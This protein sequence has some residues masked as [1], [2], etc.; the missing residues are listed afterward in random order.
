MTKI[1]LVSTVLLA[2]V[3]FVR[4]DDPAKSDANKTTS[5]TYLITGLHCP[6]CTSTVERSLS[7]APGIRSIKVDWNTKN[8]KIEFDESTVSAQKVSQLIAAT[9]HMMGPSM[10]YDSWLALKTP[11]VKDDATAKAAKDVLS[12]V[13]GVKK[14]EAFP[15]QHI[16]E[17][18]FASDGNATSAQLIDALTSAGIKA[19]NY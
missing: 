16:V 3:A 17:V 2:L 8:A 13:A 1:F 10:H 15:A 14:A 4:A 6:P 7:K 19:E 5:V 11:D 18:Q 12:K 9:P